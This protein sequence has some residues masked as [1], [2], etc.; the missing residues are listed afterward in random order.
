MNEELIKE[1]A[2]SA[3]FD[4]FCDSIYVKNDEGI[5]RATDEVHR[6]TE[7][8]VKKCATFMNEY[9]NRTGNDLL[10]HFGVK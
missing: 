1:I 8:I 4:V 5:H 3:G 7:L 2:Q 6:Y 9:A 10:N